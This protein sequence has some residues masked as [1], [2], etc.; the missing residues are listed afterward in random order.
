MIE[1]ENGEVITAADHAAAIVEGTGK[2]VPLVH[3]VT[4]DTIAEATSEG[5]DFKGMLEYGRSVGGPALRAMTFHDRARICHAR[6]GF[7]KVQRLL[8]RRIA[9]LGRERMKLIPQ[10]D[11]FARR[12]RREHLHIRQRERFSSGFWGAE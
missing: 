10:T 8:R 4:G 11:D 2:A 5:L 6:C 3:A 7:Q 1:L 12:A 9:E